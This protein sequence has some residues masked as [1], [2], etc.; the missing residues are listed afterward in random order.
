MILKA[1]LAVFLLMFL[2]LL[3]CRHVFFI[4]SRPAPPPSLHEEKKKPTIVIKW[5]FF[6]LFFASFFPLFSSFYFTVNE[7]LKTKL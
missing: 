5:P 3:K 2:E 4:I 1:L 7:T 6:L